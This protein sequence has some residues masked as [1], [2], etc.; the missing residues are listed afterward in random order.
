MYYKKVYVGMI[1]KINAEGKLKPLEI[2]WQD[3]RRYK[4]DRVLDERSAPPDNVGSYLTKKYKVLIGGQ[5]K[6]I[7][8]ETQTNRWF[9]E[10][11]K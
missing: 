7:Y 6:A 11:K 5:E 4:I 8:E 10:V 2:E 9:V 3:G 1:L